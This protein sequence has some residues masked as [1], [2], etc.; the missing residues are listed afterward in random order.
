MTWLYFI[1][2]IIVVLV[3]SKQKRH[4]ENFQD[5]KVGSFSINNLKCTTFDQIQQNI[6]NTYKIS[7]FPLPLPLDTIK[8]PPP[9]LSIVVGKEIAFVEE[10]S[11][12]ISDEQKQAIDKY[13]KSVLNEFIN[14]CKNGGLLYDKKYLQNVTN[15]I[16][17]LSLQLKSIY[18]RPRPYQLAYYMGKTIIPRPIIHAYTPSYPSYST[19]LAKTLANVLT[20]N[21]PTH[22]TNLHAIAK[23]IELSRIMGG[24]NYSS[25]NQAS[26]QIAAIIKKYIKYF[27]ITKN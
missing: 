15:D 9:N 2:C 19:L 6:I 3:L 24:F 26:L 5:I 14:Y 21:N 1:V 12:G 20:Y 11:K 22:A 8:S 13:E 18:Q 4:F 7:L 25:D 27:E 23:E 16:N 10:M 17:S